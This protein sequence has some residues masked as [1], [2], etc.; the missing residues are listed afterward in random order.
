MASSTIAAHA[1]LYAYLGRT[2]LAILTLPLVR[3]STTSNI[4]SGP[5]GCFLN[6]KIQAP[7]AGSATVNATSKFDEIW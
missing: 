4:R 6:H 5:S 3:A 2:K 7:G 1:A